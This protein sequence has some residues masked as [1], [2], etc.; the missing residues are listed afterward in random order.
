[1]KKAFW[2]KLTNELK[3]DPPNLQTIPSILKDIN[4]AF[5]SLVHKNKQFRDNINE[6]IDYDFLTQLIE[7]NSFSF[8]HIFKL[9]TFMITTLK[10]VGMVEKDK[11]IDELLQWIQKTKQKPTEF[12]LHVFLPKLFKEVFSRIEEIQKRLI[13]LKKLI[14]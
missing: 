7:K 11:E 3:E 5:L 6:V 8:E 9:A 10:Q 2:T 13:Q 4:K 1:M 12:K 14:T